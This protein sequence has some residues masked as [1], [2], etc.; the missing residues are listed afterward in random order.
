M[1]NLCCYVENTKQVQGFCVA[2][3]VRRCCEVEEQIG[4]YSGSY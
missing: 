2:Y 1:D 3:Y 4:G